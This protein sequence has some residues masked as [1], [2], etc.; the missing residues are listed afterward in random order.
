M[1]SGD[2]LHFMNSL[3]LHLSRFLSRLLDRIQLRMCHKLGYE[4]RW[5]ETSR[6]RVH[7]L[8]YQG[9]GALPPVLLVHGL[10]SSAQ[11]FEPL[12]R[13]LQGS[14]RQV[15]AID[16]VGHGGS[17]R[18]ETPPTAADLRGALA[19]A[20]DHLLDEPAVV[21]GNSL[22]GYASIGLALDHPELVRQLLLS[23]PGGAPMSKDELMDVLSVFRMRSHSDAMAFMHRIMETRSWWTPLMA[24]SCLGR[25]SSPHMKPLLARIAQSRLLT[26]ED[27]AA[28][29]VPAVVMWGK[30]E[31]LLPESSLH[32]FQA[33]FPKG[34]QFEFPERAGHVPHADRPALVSRRLR[35]LAQLGAAART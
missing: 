17:Y 26:A 33:H 29:T 34:T 9:E 13:H 14:F 5:V 18:P 8:C 22:G 35:A 32:F 16:L 20:A 1:T 2:T 30:G 6:G 3:A 4:S 21:Y 23:S 31:R 25:L 24:Q 15:V 19:E 28:L 11:D 27:V 7:A 12:M 10:S